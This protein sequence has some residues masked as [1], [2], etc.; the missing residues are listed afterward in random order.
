[1]EPM[2]HG[3]KD[4]KVHKI[5]HEW[6]DKAIKSTA[7]HKVSLLSSRSRRDE[8]F[9][10][11]LEALVNIRYEQ[12]GALAQK[13]AEAVLRAYEEFLPP[14]IVTPT[15]EMLTKRAAQEIE[16]ESLHGAKGPEL[17]KSDVRGELISH[18][19]VL[20]G[21]LRPVWQE[22]TVRCR[23]WFIY[24]AQRCFHQALDRDNALECPSPSKFADAMEYLYDHVDRLWHCINPNCYDCQGTPWFIGKN[25]KPR[26]Y[27]SLRC[28]GPARKEAKLKWWRRHGDKKRRQ[29]KTR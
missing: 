17:T 9:R 10:A 1:M 3:Q 8:T 28:M 13:D 25:A 22:P 2:V 19:W 7:S 11:F 5:G 29:K 18:V 12:G 21:K 27:C 6:R 20:A 14:R 23:R 15:L 26:T 4:E 16:V 24:E